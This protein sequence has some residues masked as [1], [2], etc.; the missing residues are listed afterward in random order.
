RG[1]TAV[2]TAVAAALLFSAGSHGQ[3]QT[4]APPAYKA[5]RLPYGGD[6]PNLNGTW[7]VSNSAYWDL[8]DHQEARSTSP[9]MGGWDAIPPG[10]SVEEGNE[11]PY[12]PEAL[13]K[14]KANFEKRFDLDPEMK[15]Y[16][17]GV[18]RPVYMPYPFKI[19]QTPNQILMN[20]AYANATRV[21]DMT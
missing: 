5:A 15:C 8:Q 11:I 9:A 17:P 12:K 2:T 7:Q 13:A 1:A 4:Q 16:L 3:A 6:V 10:M 18:P 14:K 19:V 21:I 20:F